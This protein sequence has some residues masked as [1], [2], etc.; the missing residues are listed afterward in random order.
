MKL[1]IKQVEKLKELELIN[2][3]IKKIVD[4]FLLAIND[5]P[6]MVLSFDDFEFVVSSLIKGDT[7]KK[8]I[9]DF[10]QTANLEKYAWQCE[11]L[12]QINHVFKF[13]S[14]EISL[15][16]IIEDVKTKMDIE[17]SIWYKS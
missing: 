16:E 14:K 11:S 8:N 7:L 10:L 1:Y 15:K 13:Y 3:D 5:W 12:S 17:S 9:D 4:I 6:E 2:T